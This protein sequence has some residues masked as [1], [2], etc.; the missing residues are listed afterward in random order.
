MTFG[1]RL[2]QARNRKRLTQNQV[3]NMLGIDF[4][5]ISKYE[6]NKSQPDHEILRELA[7]V[8]EVSLDWLLTGEQADEKGKSPNRI[9]VGGVQETL[10]DE[11][12]QHLL[13][14][15]EMY[16]LLK[17]KRQKERKQSGEESGDAR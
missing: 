2:R 7:S 6:N 10:T 9:T 13:D 5:T 8:Y 16:R 11:E 3:A 4:T 17:A 14:S 12:A 1:K 15:L